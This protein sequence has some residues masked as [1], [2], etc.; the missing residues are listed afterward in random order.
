MLS[1]DSG[2]YTVEYLS[3]SSWYLPSPFP[4]PGLSRGCGISLNRVPTHTPPLLCV[5]P[6]DSQ[7]SAFI[8]GPTP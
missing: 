3:F 4:P 8:P 6:T 5:L 7:F 2:K 1:Q